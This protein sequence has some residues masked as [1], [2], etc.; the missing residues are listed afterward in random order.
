MG[1]IVCHKVDPG[2][3]NLDVGGSCSML[4]S[5]TATCSTVIFSIKGT[6]RSSGSSARCKSV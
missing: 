6:G 5:A 1:N 4:V 2:E 3:Q